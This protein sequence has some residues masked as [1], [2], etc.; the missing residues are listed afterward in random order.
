MVMNGEK[1]V[2]AALVGLSAASASAQEHHATLTLT[3]MPGTPTEPGQGA[4]AAIAETVALLQS[5]PATDWASTDIEALRQ[6]LI[7]LDNVTMRSEVA[8]GPVPGG[9]SFRVTSSDVALANSIRRRVTAH[10][11]TMDGSGIWKMTAVPSPSGAEITVIGAEAEAN[12]VD[13]YRAG[14]A[15]SADRDPVADVR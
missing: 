10:T 8:V 9:A 3:V 11:A 2:C 15:R 1:L 7:D 4:F 5:D 13:G 14:P 6:H 12:A